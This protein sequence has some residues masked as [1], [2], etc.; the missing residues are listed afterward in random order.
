M[1]SLMTHEVIHDNAK[2][3]AEGKFAEMCRE[4][5]INQKK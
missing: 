5:G 1:G 4:Q 3:L 2:E